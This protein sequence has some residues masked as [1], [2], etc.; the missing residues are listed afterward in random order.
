MILTNKRCYFVES[1]GHVVHSRRGGFLSEESMK[2]EPTNPTIQLA[3][4]KASFHGNNKRVQM[5]T[6]L[7][8]LEFADKISALEVHQKSLSHIEMNTGE[9]QFERWCERVLTYT[10]ISLLHNHG[11]SMMAQI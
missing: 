9:G 1:L 4:W 2:K 11:E 3:F 10:H 5:N 8:S 7:N 6:K